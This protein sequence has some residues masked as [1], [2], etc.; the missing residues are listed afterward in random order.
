MTDGFRALRYHGRP[1]APEARLET[2][3]LADL[4]EG[5]TVIDVAFAGVNYKD[6]L[7]GRGRNKIIRELP[8]IGG[9][10]LAG[11][12]VES[13]DPSLAPGTA[14]VVHGFGVGVEHDGGFAE[15][16]RVPASWV[17]PLPDGL[18]VRDAAV[19]GVA[20]YTS[21]LS[22]HR[23]ETL[24]LRP[25][26]GPVVVTGAS[27]GSGSIAVDLLAGLGYEVSVVTGK[28]SQADWF[29]TLGAS[30]VIARDVLIADGRP[31]LTARWAGA[32]DTVGG[33]ALSWLVRTMRPDGLIAAFGNAGGLDLKTSVLP[34]I[35]R[36]VHLVGINGNS[37]MALRREVWGR[38]AGDM[39][40]RHL[41]ML[42]EEIGL[43][44]LPHAFDR[45]LA[46]R[47]RGRL[48]VD[49]TR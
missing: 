19:L 3:R 20:G 5:D 33:D 18:S 35:L 2:L 9:I 31:M 6:A 37:P 48:V 29:A 26:S 45:V 1:E 24:G 34:F 47:V 13:A 25:A 23:L 16:A 7:A 38:L 11:R 14:V 28:P 8:R 30:E 43:A 46:G 39:K 32:V 10:D 27:G 41:D 49:L 42:T 44:D 12:I 21:A 22:I 15:R 36:S 40:P 4:S 17:L